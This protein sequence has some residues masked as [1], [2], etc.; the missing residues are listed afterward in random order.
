MSQVM[1]RSTQHD[2]LGQWKQL[3]EDPT[4]NNLPYKIETNERGQLILSPV[5]K[6]HSFLQSRIMMMLDQLLEAGYAMPEVSILTSAGVRAADVA[7]ASIEHYDSE[8]EELFTKAPEICVEVWSPS[9]TLEEFEQKKRLYFEAGA[10]EVW[11][12]SRDGQMRFFVSTAE[13][14]VSGLVAGF[15]SVIDQNSSS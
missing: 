15:P 12:C 6:R 2:A 10:L 5:S 3:L 9:N 14:D 13:L 4:L 7:W 8:P 1:A 11:T